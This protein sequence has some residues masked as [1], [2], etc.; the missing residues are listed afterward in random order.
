MV[1]QDT[2]SR[3]FGFLLIT[4]SHALNHVYDA[5]LPVLYP[6]II[7]EFNLSY[8]FVGL[9]VMGYRLSSGALQLVVGFLGRFVRRKVLLGVGMIWQSLMN[10]FVALSSRFEHIFVSRTFAGIGASPQ[11]PT[12]AAFIAEHFPPSQVGRAMGLNV[13]AA[14]VGRFLAPFLGTLLLPLVGWRSAILV[15]SLPGLLVG[16]AFLFITEPRRAGGEAGLSRVA[17]FSNG[18]RAVIR[19]RTVLM[20]LLLETVM[21]FR[22]GAADFIPSYLIRDMGIPSL[23]A[24]V[25]FTVFLGAG[26]PAPYFWG[27]LS[28]RFERKKILTVVMALA[29][30]FWFLLPYGRSSAQ[31]LLLLIP[32][33]F[34]CQGVGGIIQAYVA[35]VTPRENRDLIYG[36]FF[37]LAYVLGSFSPVIQ[38]YLADTIG[39]SVSFTYVAFISSLAAIVSYF[40][41]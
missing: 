14:Q 4:L 35:V 25:L 2:R 28:D 17:A 9:V 6:S 36:I 41:H 11:H 39:F 7:S 29:T 13:T 12:G 33:G 18:V 23:E 40:L 21:A 37:T 16:I 32:L 1:E 22:A 5:L 19:N 34:V 20:I 3:A 30:L 10:V 24:G 31:F 8:S 15:F 38:G 26:I 27:Y